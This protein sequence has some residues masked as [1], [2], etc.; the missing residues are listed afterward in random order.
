MKKDQL[1]LNVHIPND[2]R[3]ISLSKELGIGWVRV[4]MNWN[5]IEPAKGQYHWAD[6]DDAIQKL[7]AAGLTIYATLAYSPG[8]ANGNQPRTAPPLNGADFA[9]FVTQAVKRYQGKILYWGIWNEPNLPAF[10]TGSIA[11]YLAKILAPGADAVHAADS[12]AKVA[13]PDLSHSGDVRDA[14]FWY[15][16]MTTILAQ[17]GQRLDVITHHIYKEPSAWELWR[18]LDGFVFPYLEGKNLRNTLSACGVA[19]KPL[20]ITEIGWKSNA[21]GAGKQAS[22]Y[23]DFFAGIASRDWI[24]KVFFYELNDVAGFSELWG[25]VDSN[26]L[27]KPAYQVI[28]S[29]LNAP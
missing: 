3:Q 22:N 24:S 10:Y 14:T 7:L 25:I 12:A 16:W 23:T 9:A 4:D 20:W 5:G 8:W 15:K 6:M 29:Q 19:G 13:G 11:D 2:P 26:F 27:K 21:G 17:H 18:R 1:G 28:Q